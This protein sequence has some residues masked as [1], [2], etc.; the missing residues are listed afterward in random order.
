MTEDPAAVRLR[1][2]QSSQSKGTWA[3]PVVFALIG[4]ALLAWTPFLFVDSNHS[5]TIQAGEVQTVHVESYSKTHSSS[6][7]GSDKYSYFT[8]TWTPPGSSTP[9]QVEVR[10][11]NYHGSEGPFIKIRYTKDDPSD[12]EVDGY[13]HN[14]FKKTLVVGLFGVGLAGVGGLIASVLLKNRRELRALESGS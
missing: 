9:E 13:P 2:L 4:V 14:T 6:Q 12:R 10:A 5:R 1:Q 3:I 8:V 11:T 7:N